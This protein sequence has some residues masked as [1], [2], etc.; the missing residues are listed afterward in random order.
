MRTCLKGLLLVGFATTQIIAAVPNVSAADLKLGPAK[1]VA[2]HHHHHRAVRSPAVRDYDGTPVV[3][4]RHRVVVR[5]YDGSL[6]DSYR[7]DVIPVQRPQ[8]YH[9][10]NGEP[11]LPLYP[12]GW[13]RQATSRYATMTG[14]LYR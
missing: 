7:T 5:G 1:R 9:Y 2:A 3:V 14:Q 11:V 8:P 6:V 13:P 12:R 4:V 10:M